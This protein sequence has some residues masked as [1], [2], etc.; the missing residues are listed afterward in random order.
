MVRTHRNTHSAFTDRSARV[1]SIRGL[2]SSGL[3]YARS[4]RRVLVLSRRTAAI[5]RGLPLDAQAR[6]GAGTYASGCELF[7]QVF[8]LGSTFCDAAGCPF[9]LSDEHS[10]LPA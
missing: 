3:V 7:P 8:A 6:T 2:A 5:A 10:L 9:Q 1:P 4:A